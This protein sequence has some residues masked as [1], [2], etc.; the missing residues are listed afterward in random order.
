MLKDTLPRMQ[1]DI[2]VVSPENGSGGPTATIVCWETGYNDVGVGGTLG[3]GARLIKSYEAAQALCESK[4]LVMV[5]VRIEYS[6]Q[7]LDLE[8]LEPAN[9]RVFVNSLAVNLG[10]VDVFA[11]TSAPYACDPKTQM[12][13]ADYWTHT[14]TNHATALV[15]DG[16]HHTKAGVDGINRLW[17]GVADRMIYTPQHP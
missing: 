1:H 17:A 3:L 7:Y 10:G 12:P 14:R 6:T 16:V 8:T 5:P 11:R 13:Y 4:G 2:P 15:K 9:G